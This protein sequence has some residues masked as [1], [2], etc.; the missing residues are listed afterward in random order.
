MRMPPGHHYQA[1]LLGVLCPA[2][3]QA[4]V[5]LA[6]LELL[7]GAPHVSLSKATRTWTASGSTTSGITVD[8]GTPCIMTCGHCFKNKKQLSHTLQCQ[9]AHYGQ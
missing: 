7:Q 9:Y 4:A 1:S 2:E 6:Q 8:A 5:D 3:P